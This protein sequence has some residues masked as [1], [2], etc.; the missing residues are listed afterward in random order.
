M[1]IRRGYVRLSVAV[2]GTWI[3]AWGAV[4]AYAAWQQGIHSQIF[5]ESSQRGDPVEVLA[6]SSEAA[7]G[8]G[9]LVATALAWGVVG[10][11]CIALL[12]ALG[13][14]VYRGF[15]PHDSDNTVQ[16]SRAGKN[17]G[18]QTP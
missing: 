7:S 15:V 8:Y 2:V 3:A 14:W 9:E 4:G 6:I 5:V 11:P 12:F 18:D 10:A 16:T 17:K 1:N 13:W